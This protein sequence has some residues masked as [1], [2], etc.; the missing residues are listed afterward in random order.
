MLF[1]TSRLIGER[2]TPTLARLSSVCQL[3]WID[4]TRLVAECF[5]VVAP[6]LPCALLVKQKEFTFL[7][8]YCPC[9]FSELAHR[10]R[11]G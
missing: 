10:Q 4:L 9:V 2:T 1:L 3:F 5:R 8:S 7:R 11:I 6:D